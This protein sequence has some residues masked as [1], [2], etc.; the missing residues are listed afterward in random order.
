VKATGIEAREIFKLKSEIP[1]TASYH[2]KLRG[3][4]SIFA[5][6]TLK[7]YDL[8]SKHGTALGNLSPEY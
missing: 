1:N 2:I 7:I 3:S 4:S 6:K 8:A 5:V